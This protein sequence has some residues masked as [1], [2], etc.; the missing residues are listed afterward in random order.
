MRQARTRELALSIARKVWSSRYVSPP[1]AADDIDNWIPLMTRLDTSERD[2]LWRS[3]YRFV[4]DRNETA[5]ENA[6]AQGSGQSISRVQKVDVETFLPD[7][8]LVKVDIT[9]MAFGLEVRPPILDRTVFSTA[10]RLRQ[11]MKVEFGPDGEFQGKL[12]LKRLAARRFGSEFAFRKKQGFSVPLTR[13]LHSDNGTESS[14]E[15]RLTDPSA[16]LMEWFDKE[17]LK[18]VLRARDGENT[19]LLLV[20]DEW[21]R[22][23]CAP[24]SVA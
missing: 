19:W 14:I 23:Q 12:P 1:L 24:A 13:W 11:N 4:T 18:S 3:E 9:S 21:L 10:R 5:L 15:E 7:D 6:L 2:S 8:I 22:Q 17:G 20:L 16:P